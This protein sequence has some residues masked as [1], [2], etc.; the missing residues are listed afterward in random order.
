MSIFDIFVSVFLK[1]EHYEVEMIS[2]LGEYPDL[3]FQLYFIYSETFKTMF[4]FQV[5]TAI[6][7]FKKRKYAII[8]MPGTIFTISDIQTS[9]Y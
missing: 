8:T 2:D 6:D 7:S 1:S 3:L 5:H 9:N 4:L